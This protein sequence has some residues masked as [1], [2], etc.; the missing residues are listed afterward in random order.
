MSEGP[1][2]IK[3]GCRV[4]K[5]APIEGDE[6]S[7]SC[8]EFA[9]EGNSEFDDG[10]CDFVSHEKAQEIADVESMPFIIKGNKDGG[11]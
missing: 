9:C 5:C 6:E 1:V 8:E 2:Y 4:F 11:M 3:D 10:K 7:Y